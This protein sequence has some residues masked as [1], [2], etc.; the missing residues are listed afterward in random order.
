MV[1][2]LIIWTFSSLLEE[3]EAEE[4][5][6]LVAIVWRLIA[7]GSG[8]RKKK[9]KQK[10]KETYA[11]AHHGME[12]LKDGGD[13]SY[14]LEERGLL[15]EGRKAGEKLPRGDDG[16]DD[17]ESEYEEEEEVD[18]RRGRRRRRRRRR[19]GGSAST[20][21]SFQ[22][23]TPDE[24][25]AVVRKFDRRLVVFVALLYM[26]SFLDRSSKFF[27]LGSLTGHW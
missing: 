25:K 20:A 10:K 16:F 1:M 2:V 12:S 13:E 19:R 27:F 4:E 9:K 15:V 18:D 11:M 23:Y 3:R 21:A 14:E 17:S 26:L 5:I 6:W 24:E 22:L 8:W 7:T